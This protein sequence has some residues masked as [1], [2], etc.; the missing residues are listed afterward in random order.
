MR[1]TAAIF[2]SAALAI[3]ISS[4]IRPSSVQEISR[5]RAIEIARGQVSFQPASVTAVLTTSSRRRVWRVTLRGRLPGQPPL[6]F[7]TVSVEVDR[8]NGDIV[9]IAR[10]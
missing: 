5:E 4:S 7:E 9:S 2:L 8:R 10:P 6:L 3:M 1:R